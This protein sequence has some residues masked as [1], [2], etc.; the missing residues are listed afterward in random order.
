MG[1]FNP[2]DIFANDAAASSDGYNPFSNGAYRRYVQGDK[3]A[4]Q[5]ETFLD[6]GLSHLT[7][8]LVGHGNSGGNVLF[9]NRYLKSPC[10]AL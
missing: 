1:F 4:K 7:E 5:M 10:F 2:A 6:E 8:S 3:T 9:V